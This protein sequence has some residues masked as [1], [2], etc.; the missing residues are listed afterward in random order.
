M[1]AEKHMKVVVI[2]SGRLG[3][4]LNRMLKDVPGFESILVGKDNLDELDYVVDILDW[5]EIRDIIRDE[6][7]FAVV[8]CAALTDVERTETDH[9]YKRKAFDVNVD[10]ALK[11][12]EFARDYGA[13]NIFI[14]TDYV[15]SEKSKKHEDGSPADPHP[16]NIYGRNKLEAE[17]FLESIFKDSPSMNL[18]VRC[19]WMYDFQDKAKKS[20]FPSKILEV[21]YRGISSTVMK[22]SLPVDTLGYPVR[23]EDVSRGIIR[24]LLEKSD[25]QDGH[26][27][28][29]V[30]FGYSPKG[31]SRYEFGQTIVDCYNEAYLKK[32]GTKSPLEGWTFEK[33]TQAD[34]GRV[35]KHPKEVDYGNMRNICCFNGRRDVEEYIERNF[36]SLKFGLERK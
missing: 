28:T 8:N 4:T 29:V 10:S 34:T 6:K 20:D 9:D 13:F 14:S 12:G 16:I 2:G 22:P 26:Y 21:A 1:E 36:Y 23:Y 18:N 27:G 5:R 7:P 30:A 25:G 32:T 33:G 17:E 31:I 15:W 24:E 3:R 19:S 35:A 11:I